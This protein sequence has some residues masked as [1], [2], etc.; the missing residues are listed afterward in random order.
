MEYEELKTPII[1]TVANGEQLSAKGKGSVR[2]T[3]P[4]NRVVKLTNVLYVPQLNRK[5]ISASA[6]TAHDGVSVQFD[7]NR[8]TIMVNGKFLGQNLPKR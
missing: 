4:T 2:F 5:L 3:I 6:L 7:H 1:I 8:A